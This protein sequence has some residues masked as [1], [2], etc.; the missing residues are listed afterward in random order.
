VWVDTYR[1]GDGVPDAFCLSRSGHWVALEIKSPGGRLTRAEREFWDSLP[2]SAPAEII[3]G[4][5]QFYEVMYGYDNG[6]I[7]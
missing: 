2:E 1:Q 7:R 5:D 4:I 6:N 3:Y